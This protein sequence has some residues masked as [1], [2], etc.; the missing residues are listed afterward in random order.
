MRQ[1]PRRRSGR[2]IRISRMSEVLFFTPRAELEPAANV[3]AFIEVCRNSEVLGAKKQFEKNSW[4]IGFFKG[5]NKT[6]RAVFSTLEA[7]GRSESEPSMPAPF[8]DFAKAM[9]VYQHDKRPVTSQGPRVAALRCIEA[10]LRDHNLGSRPTAVNEVILDSAVDLARRQVSPAVAYRIA[11]QIEAVSELMRS[12]GFITLRRRWNHG[13]PK[14]RELGSRISKEALE[15]RQNK[16]PSA[17]ALRAIGGIFQEATRPADV[18]V[19]SHTALLCCAPERMN[20]ALRLRRNC[21]VEGEGEFKGRLGVRWPGSKGFADMVEW[22][23]EEMVFLAREALSNIKRVTS[24][25]QELAAWYTENPTK[26]FLHKAVQHLRNKEILTLD[27]I[28]EIIW[29]G[30]APRGSART[31][32][33]DTH[34]LTQVS[35]G[36][37]RVGYRFEDV[38]RAVLSMLPSTFPCVPGAPELQCQDSLVV[39]RTNEMSPGKATYL[40][41]FCCID[42]NVITNHFGAREG[43]SVSI[44]DRFNYTEDD[45]SPIELISHSLR[46]YLN[47]LAQTGGLTGAQIA[48][49]SGRKDESQNR[50]YDHQ[51]SAEVQRPIAR[52]LKNGFTSNIAPIDTKP[53]ALIRQEDYRTRSSGIGHSNEYGHCTHDFAAAPCH[54]N[55]NCLDCSEQMCIKGDR[56]K[57]ANLRKRKAETEFQM[58]VAQAAMRDDEY[59]ADAWVRDHTKTLERIN[60]LLAIFDDPDV[61]DGAQIRLAVDNT[62]LITTGQVHP[63]KFVRTDHQQRLP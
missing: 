36:G 23:T 55:R 48:A 37:R 15:A 22:V 53:R 60:A 27:E 34:A 25:A 3:D 58:R 13:V 33:K 42:Y 20:E 12:M 2:R 18:L 16:L 11:G 28:N 4:D 45:G 10:A 52:A 51:T 59:N 31:F 39:M 6:N 21:I 9:L 43:R 50:S 8:V 63:L 49:F 26:I 47:M 29:G 54:L 19:I 41:M 5:H 40:C 7:S 62:P 56:V 17:A 38:E 57:E 14:P 32:A 24:P 44:F 1:S 61:A 30:Q 35:L 46:H